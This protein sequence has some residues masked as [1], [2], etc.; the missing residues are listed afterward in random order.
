M[1]SVLYRA[2]RK[3]VLT[4]TELEKAQGQPALGGVQ[5]GMC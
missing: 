2:T 4:F 1:D 5:F 3:M